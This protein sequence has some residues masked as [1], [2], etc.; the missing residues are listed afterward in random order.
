MTI[1]NTTVV[2]LVDTDPHTGDLCLIIS[3][4]LDWYDAGSKLKIL[5]AKIEAYV[6]AIDSGEIYET[7]PEHRNRPVRIEVFSLH[8][9]S[10]PAAKPLRSIRDQLAS[11]GVGFQL[12]VGPFQSGF[13]RP[14]QFLDE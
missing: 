7:I 14:Y 8:P 6:H 4:H 12:M 5:A 11:H 3:D 9:P 10:Q 1:D 13:T 2:D